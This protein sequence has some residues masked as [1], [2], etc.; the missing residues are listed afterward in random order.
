VI[1]S[2]NLV[3]D[4]GNT[5]TKTAI[6]DQNKLIELRSF[7]TLFVC[8]I[9]LMLRKHH[10][11]NQ[12]IISV[13]GLF[14]EDLKSYL[15]ITFPNFI[16]LNGYSQLPF[17][18]TY[19]SKGTQGSDRI[20]AIAGAQFLFPKINVLVIDAGTAITYDV[21]DNQSVYKGGSISPGL[22]TRYK[23][24][25]Y[26]TQKLPLLE[27]KETFDIIGTNT[28]QAIISGVQNGLV[29]EI[30]GYITRLKEVYSE[31]EVLLSG[32]DSEFISKNIKY[33]CKLEP[34]LVLIGLN[35]ILNF[36]RIN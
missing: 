27:K 25:N 3:V 13:T 28:P 32:G 29:F 12:C 24:L 33:I 34:D 15:K 31:L 36:I 19:E 1:N 35:Q 14:E 23:A 2:K 20:A 17:T 10:E 26:F 7:K 16:E 4:L 21:I 9:E 18:N 8:D 11:I 5:L 6:Y 22:Q 30:E